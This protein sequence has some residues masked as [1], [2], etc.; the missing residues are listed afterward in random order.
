MFQGIHLWFFNISRGKITIKKRSKEKFRAD[1]SFE[2]SSLIVF[3]GK[4]AI[5]KNDRP[6]DKSE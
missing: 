3:K 4:A 6:P 2:I 1:N 5:F